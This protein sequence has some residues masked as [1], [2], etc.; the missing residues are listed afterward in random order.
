[1]RKADVPDFVQIEENRH[2]VRD[3]RSMAILNLDTDA[4]ARYRAQR[5]K[6]LEDKQKIAKLENDVAELKSLVHQLLEKNNA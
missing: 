4:R 2:L 6:I 1:M 5:Q 3:T